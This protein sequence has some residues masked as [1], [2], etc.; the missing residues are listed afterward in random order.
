MSRGG[1]FDILPRWVSVG[2]NARSGV[3]HV[4]RDGLW[5]ANDWRGPLGVF[6]TSAEAE[7]AIRTA[8]ARSPKKRLPRDPPPVALQFKGLTP[9]DAGYAVF[10]RRRQKLGAV[11][12]CGGGQYVAWSRVE[13]PGEFRTAAEAEA[14]VI[15]QAARRDGK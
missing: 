8:P 4:D 6:P 15:Q 10:D 12:R 7:E 9:G 14:A 2:S 13:K 11:I 1:K 3:I 5:H